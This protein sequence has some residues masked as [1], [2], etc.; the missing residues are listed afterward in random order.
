MISS[1]NFLYLL[2]IFPFYNKVQSE[3][4][5]IKLNEIEWLKSFKHELVIVNGISAEMYAH[6]ITLLIIILALFRSSS[7]LPAYSSNYPQ[8]VNAVT[9]GLK[10]GNNEECLKCNVSRHI[11]R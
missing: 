6:L 4:S 1:T 7:R 8:T 5:S 3:Y 10:P 9:D 11:S 2:Q